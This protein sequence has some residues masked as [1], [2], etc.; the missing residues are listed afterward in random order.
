MHASRT[1][2]DSLFGLVPDSLKTQQR[3]S[4]MVVLGPSDFL[5]F[6]LDII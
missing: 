1:G 5:S 2:P 6:I 3:V 4:R